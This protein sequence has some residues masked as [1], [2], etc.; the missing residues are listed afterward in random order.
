MA[1]L[2]KSRTEAIFRQNGGVFETEEVYMSIGRIVTTLTDEVC[3]AI[4]DS[5]SLLRSDVWMSV[6]SDLLALNEG[7]LSIP[8]GL[9]DDQFEDWVVSEALKFNMESPFRNESRGN[10][11]D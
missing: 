10:H 8:E 7:I 1:G 3:I 5:D 9:A 2:T 6:C 4:S 11:G